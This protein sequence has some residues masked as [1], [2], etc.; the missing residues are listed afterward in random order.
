MT[1]DLVLIVDLETTEG[2][3]HLVNELGTVLYS[4]KHKTIIG[5]H[6]HLL[7]Y[8]D[9]ELPTE[10]NTISQIP[11]AAIAKWGVHPLPLMIGKRELVS[12]FA[13]FPSDVEF[14]I[15]HNTDHEKQ[16]IELEDDEWLCTYRDFELFP[17]DDYVGKRDLF[18]MAITNG[19]G[20][21]QGHRAI[22]DCLL[23]AEIFNRRPNLAQDFTF[24]QIPHIEVIAP[25]DAELPDG[26][27]W[28]RYRRGWFSRGTPDPTNG[29]F[30]LGE[31]V[32]AIALAGYDQKD[33]VKSYG[34]YF[35]SETKTWR[36]P[37]NV[38]A[39]EAYPFGLSLNIE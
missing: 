3:R 26:W 23:I 4:V 2:D 38:H 1:T 34:F 25:M 24:A 7:N 6:S 36:K 13:V 27:K 11:Q 5:C 9:S 8:P 10:E 21:S 28:D 31:R 14:V 37:V 32:E 12:P 30:S 20:I 22:Y 35:Q 18:S 16:Y 19:V 17:N 15:A 39:M 29:L 33:L